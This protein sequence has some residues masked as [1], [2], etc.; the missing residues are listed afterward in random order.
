MWWKVQSF[1]QIYLAGLSRSCTFS[2]LDLAGA[3]NIF[4]LSVKNEVVTGLF[5]VN[6]PSRKYIE[7]T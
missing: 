7:H 6:L 4:V 5:F 1:F 3:G 2:F